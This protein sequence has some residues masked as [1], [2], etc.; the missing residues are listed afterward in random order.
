M[1]ATFPAI[2][3]TLSI[4]GTIEARSQIVHGGDEK[5][6]STPV[7][8]S[9][10]HYDPLTG[11]EVRLPFI[12][13][14]AIRGYLRR[15]VMRDMV[16]QL[17]ITLDNP[18][19]FHAL[20]TGGVLESTDETTGMVDLALRARVRDL[21][22][23]LGLFGTA[24]G[25][26]MV[27]GCLKVDHAMPI[28]REYAAY[29]DDEANDPRASRPI[30]SFT[31]IS[32]ATRKDELRAEREDDEQAMQMLVEFEAFIAGTKFVHGFTLVYPSALE[33]ACLGRAVELWREQP[34]VGGKSGSGYGRIAMAYTGLPDAAP[35]LAHLERGRAEIAEVLGSLFGK[36]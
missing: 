16:A 27:P 9:I 1:T 3:R 35:Y 36:R 31:D 12:S 15:L 4:P 20:M 17:G 18:K 30:R 34:Y 29:L 22:P 26:Q 8:R 23:P 24:I 5:T 28:C 13:G 33:A 19:L 6:G 14:N 10:M 21:V 25:N 7:L 2:T 32:F 11:R